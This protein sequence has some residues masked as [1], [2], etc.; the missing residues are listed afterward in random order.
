LWWSKL[1]KRRSKG[2][3]TA[4]WAAQTAFG[5]R[6]AVSCNREWKWCNIKHAS[7]LRI[8][9]VHAQTYEGVLISP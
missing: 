7:L 3:E 9:S 5:A 2:E 6:R 8:L 1:S 4:C